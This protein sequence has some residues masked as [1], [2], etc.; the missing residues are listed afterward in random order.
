MK[1][2]E[3]V[4]P[5]GEAEAEGEGGKLDEVIKE[6]QLGT[7]SDVTIIAEEIYTNKEDTNII[8]IESNTEGVKEGK[9]GEELQE[10][11]KEEVTGKF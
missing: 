11:E 8:E 5:K 10:E 4:E 2:K 9:K 6:D 1:K 7:Q 3:H